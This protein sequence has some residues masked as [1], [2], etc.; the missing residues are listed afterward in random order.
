MKIEIKIDEDCTETKIV[1]SY[2]ADRSVCT[3]G[4]GLCS[5]IGHLGT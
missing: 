1:C 5:G 2:F 4:C 3:Y